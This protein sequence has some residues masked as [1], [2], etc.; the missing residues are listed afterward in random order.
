MYGAAPESVRRSESSLTHERP[1]CEA[2]DN[3][4]RK[5]IEAEL[6]AAKALREMLTDE[7]VQDVYERLLD[8]MQARRQAER[9]ARLTKKP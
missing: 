3:A 7:D 1:A 4:T 6:A 8:M 2:K 5:A 9:A